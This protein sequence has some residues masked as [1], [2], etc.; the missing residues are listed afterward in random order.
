MIVATFGAGG[1]NASVLIVESNDGPIGDLKIDGGRIAMIATKGDVEEASRRWNV[2]HV[3]DE[4]HIRVL[5]DDAKVALV[6]DAP[7]VH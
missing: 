7:C 4:V 5:R 6:V 2:G 3:G 1:A